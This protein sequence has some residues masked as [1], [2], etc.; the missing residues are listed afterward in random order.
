MNP[1]S[2]T[3]ALVLAFVSA[4]SLAACNK[5]PPAGQ[6]TQTSSQ[7]LPQSGLAA[8]PAASPFAPGAAAHTVEVG[9]PAPDFTLKDLDGK[10][11]HLA[12]FKGK[13]VVLEWFN[14]G[15]PFVQKAHTK[16]SLKEAAKKHMGEGVVWLAVNSGAAGK[17]GHGADANREAAKKFGMDHPILVDESGQVGKTYG[18]TNTPH[19]FVIDDKGTLVY[20]GAV[21][22]SP[23]GEGESA[24]SGKLVSY[25][26]EALA[27]IAS[28]KAPETTETQAYGCGVKY[29]K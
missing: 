1:T 15:C 17:Q 28:G 12:S 3:A 23:D 24:P 5:E 22:N 9:K 16:G 7:A 25:V 18:A 11:V 14:P 4:L 19:M 8:T 21:D 27:A 10:D 6:G 2:P 20:R 26:D 29:G 13:V